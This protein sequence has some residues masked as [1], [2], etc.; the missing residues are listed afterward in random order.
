MR[1]AFATQSTTVPLLDRVMRV[2]SYESLWAVGVSL[3]RH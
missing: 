2:R 1:G 3:H